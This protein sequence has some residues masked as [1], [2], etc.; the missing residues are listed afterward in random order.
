MGTGAAAVPSQ[1]ALREA[2]RISVI[3]STSESMEGGLAADIERVSSIV[4]EGEPLR[5]GEETI[6]VTLRVT[7]EETMEIVVCAG[8]DVHAVIR[9]CLGHPVG[10]VLFGGRHIAVGDTFDDHDIQDGAK[11][12]VASAQRAADNWDCLSKDD[13]DNYETYL[14]LR[15]RETGTVIALC[16]AS[17]GWCRF[18]RGPGMPDEID[19]GGSISQQRFDDS[20]LQILA[21]LEGGTSDPLFVGTETR[22]TCANW[23][24][25]EQEDGT[26][27]LSNTQN[28]AE[29]HRRLLDCAGA[30]FESERL[31]NKLMHN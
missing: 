7:D 1:C 5:E 18:R 20:E 9:E 24:L 2:L 8:R 25:E 13:G 16:G 22:R 10:E 19:W 12:A 23:L 29:S 17:C 3:V 4:S 26:V 27:L 28:I 15:H 11:L 14:V 21:E 6:R 31:G 30:T